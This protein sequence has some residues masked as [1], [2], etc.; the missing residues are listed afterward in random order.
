M[1]TGPGVERGT[2]YTGILDLNEVK[3]KLKGNYSLA[4][5]TEF[6]AYKFFPSSMQVC[7]PAYFYE[8]PSTILARKA[9]TLDKT[10]G[11]L[12][13]S[14]LLGWAGMPDRETSA[15]VYSARKT[16][17]E[18]SKKSSEEERDPG[19]MYRAVPVLNAKLVIAPAAH[20]RFCF[21]YALGEWGI[22]N[23]P[24]GPL[25]KLH[26]CFSD[27]F[28]ACGMEDGF[29]FDW[30]LFLTTLNAIAFE[31]LRPQRALFADTQVMYGRLIAHK[32]ELLEFLDNAFLPSNNGFEVVDY[33][34]GLP[35]DQYPDNEI[36]T[37]SPCV[38]IEEGVFERMGG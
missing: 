13:M 5:A 25:G 37:A 31:E 29:P 14:N 28:R 4:L 23:A 27:L 36:W 6:P 18:F 12:L 33:T 9:A 1:S 11:N 30:P 7:C 10:M 38:L 16:A 26:G 24:Y 35:R 34:E 22:T 2:S 32:A 19:W 21:Q 15:M 20:L 17:E 8:P 3:E